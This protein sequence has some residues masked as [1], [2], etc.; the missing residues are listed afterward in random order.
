MATGRWVLTSAPSATEIWII[1]AP[2]NAVQWYGGPGQ[3]QPGAVHVTGPGI[4]DGHL[5]W[6][7]SP[8]GLLLYSGSWAPAHVRHDRLGRRGVLLTSHHKEHMMRVAPPSQQQSRGNI[9]D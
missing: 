9:H 1:S 2:G 7:G 6:L 3:E 8:E 5:L 4:R